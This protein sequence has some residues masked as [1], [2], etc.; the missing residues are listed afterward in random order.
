VP[1][2]FELSV[3]LFLQLA[4]VLAACRLVGVVLRRLGQTQVVA[5][6]VA[7]FLL[8]PSLLG[9]LNPSVQQW[10]FPSTIA[11]GGEA[12]ATTVGH[13]S[14]SIVYA[15]GQ[16]GLVL[17]MFS[18]GLGLNVGILVRH[19]RHTA[20]MSLSGVAAPLIMGGT[21][22]V[23]LLHQSGGRLFSE[24]VHPW[25][26][27][28]FVGAAIAITAFPMLARIVWETGIMNTRVGTLS[29]ACAGVDD[30]VAWILLAL[31]VAAAA[32]S[33]GV[34]V[35]AL[36]GTVGYF[37][38]MLAVARPLLRRFGGWAMT[39][40]RLRPEGLVA[41]A[42]ILALCAW[43][44]DSVGVYSVFG[45]FVAGLVMPRGAF[46]D[47]LRSRIEP[48]TTAVLLPLFFIYSGLNTQINLLLDPGILL[49]FAAVLVVAIVSKGGACL[50]AARAV[51][52][53]WPESAALGS[54]MNA[55]G[56][57]ELILLNIGLQAGIITR[58]LYTVLALMTI[59]TTLAAS[60]LYALV[61]RHLPSPMPTDGQPAVLALDGPTDGDPLT[62]RV[63]TLPVPSHRS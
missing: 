4:V 27:A 31:V 2:N 20:V 6:M 58:D 53:S 19:V 39:G 11:V 14:L 56:L 57:M 24:R 30:A 49:A 50:L 17:Y 59:V 48:V 36:L 60:P 21:L 22:G 10:L 32:A 9:L 8:G 25:E 16:L 29:L 52:L 12:N 28:L 45:A 13:P 51:G 41:A 26:A 40:G 46:A 63:S 7:G 47:T 62:D 55:R 44:T 18:V 54:L 42:A 35:L 38:F 33:P 5:D 3:H 34:A 23:L 15:L 61:K 43:I 37:A 1:T